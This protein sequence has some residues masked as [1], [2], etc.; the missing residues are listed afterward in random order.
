MII[1]KKNTLINGILFLEEIK[2]INIHRRGIFKCKCESKFEATFNNVKTGQVKS[3]GCQFIEAKKARAKERIIIICKCG[4]GNEL[5]NVSSRGRNRK[6]ILG[7]NKGHNK[8]H[9]QEVKDKISIKNKGKISFNK[10][11]PNLNFIGN[12]N[13]NWKDGVTKEYDKIRK[14][15]KY[16]EWRN[17]IFK[18]DNYTCQECKCK[19]SVSGK[20]NAHHIKQFAKYPELRFDLTNG[21]TLCKTCHKKTDTYLHKGRYNTQ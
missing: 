18:R 13:P 21:I 20:L 10:G 14:S 9:T 2:K 15:I 19:E 16:K 4:C 5:I 11:K 17:K 6:F 1:Y 7:H 8:P 12:K 3:C